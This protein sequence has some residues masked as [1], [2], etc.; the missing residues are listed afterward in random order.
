[1]WSNITDEDIEAT[2][3][4]V[5]RPDEGLSDDPLSKTTDADVEESKHPRAQNGQ[6]GAGSGNEEKEKKPLA[7]YSISDYNEVL[8]NTETIKGVIVKNISNHA[9]ARCTER[10]ISSGTV[11]RILTSKKTRVVPGNTDKTVCF[12]GEGKR[13]VLDVTT[14][15]IVTVMRRKGRNKS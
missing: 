3:D 9:F 15:R 6:F 14:G 2:D 4:D 11:K 12:D 10:K 7:K 8:Q 5:L 1:M 13:I